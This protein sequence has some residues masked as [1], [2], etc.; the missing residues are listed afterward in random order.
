MPATNGTAIRISLLGRFA[1]QRGPQTLPAKKW[2][3][4]KTAALLQ[5]LALDRRL[6]RDEALDFLWPDFDPGAAANNLY[7]TLHRLRRGLDEALGPGAAQ[8]TLSFNDGVLR[9]DENV[10]VDVHAFASACQQASSTRQLQEALTLYKGP[11]LPSRLYED[12][13]ALPRQTLH[14]LYRDT[15]LRLA[16]EATA[17]ADIEAAVAHL[18]VCLAED[19]ADEVIHRQ[20]MR[21]F[22]L[23]GKRHDALRQYQACVDALDAHVGVPPMP[24]TAALHQQIL[25]NELQVVATPAPLLLA[26]KAA[27]AAGKPPAETPLVGRD[28]E[29]AKL[30]DLL[31]EAAAGEGRTVLIAGATGAGKTRLAHE[32]TGLASSSGMV[33]L[34]GAAYEYEGHLA[35][36]PFA[37]AIERWLAQQAKPGAGNPLTQFHPDGGGDPQQE[38]WALF[39]HTSTFLARLAAEAPVV[40]LLDD[41]HAADEASLQLFHYLARHTRS[42]PF[43]LLATYRTDLI[44]EPASPFSALL[45]SLYREGLRQTITL[46]PLP[47]GAIADLIHYKQG[48]AVDGS[49]LRRIVAA[50]EGNPFFAEEI[51][52]ALHESG[53]LVRQ[54]GVWHLQTARLP[55]VPSDLSQLLRERIRQ[56]GAAVASL[57][58]MA[59]VAGRSFQLEVIQRVSILDEAGL[60]DAIDGA[61]EANFIEPHDGAYQFRHE[62]IRRALYQAQSEPRLQRLHARV[63]AALEEEVAARGD[64]RRTPVES[65]AYHYE[66]SDQPE[67]ALPYLQQAGERAAEVYAFE[68]AIHHYERALALMDEQQVEDNALRWRLREALGWWEKVL[69]NTPRAV[70]HF[71][72]ALSLAP[73][74]GWQPE[75]NERARAHAGAAMALLTAGD[76]TAA[77]AHLVAAQNEIDPGAYASE[78]ADILY[79]VAQLHWHRNEYEEAFGA[80]QRSLEI[81]EQLDEPGAVARAFEMLALA[82]HSLGEWQLGLEFENRRSAIAGP[83][84]DVSDAFD[85]HL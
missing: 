80:A 55:D 43:L 64:R 38:K 71:E 14:R 57:L 32:I 24:E 46:P 72:Q 83:E 22:A 11:L 75:P 62:L 1:V 48:G 39:N 12:W 9:L 44:Q 61:L 4:R 66:R 16:E 84:L 76:T 79:N 58:E 21:L 42:R 20:L 26:R 78:Y 13:T 15:S 31:Q 17:P 63:A 59:S 77:E 50:T 27:P 28:E 45:S 6:L 34:A 36:Q 30:R 37:E 19:P 74:T 70:A 68:E 41:L 51:C 33:V 53:R 52:A 67:R 8:A 60:L 40:F 56:S 49:L 81:A 85:V 18:H 7:R 82:C 69:A 73:N 3:R 2:T 54:D 5:R 25:N 23:L 65:L 29:L 35:Y 47:D 10:W